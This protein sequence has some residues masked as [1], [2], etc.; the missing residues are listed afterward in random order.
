MKAPIILLFY[1]VFTGIVISAVSD[2]YGIN[3]FAMFL[4][5][6]VTGPVFVYLVITYEGMKKQQREQNDRLTAYEKAC[7]EERE[8]KGQH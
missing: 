2:R 8:S 1:L 6:I 5:V 7:K 3:S 4:V